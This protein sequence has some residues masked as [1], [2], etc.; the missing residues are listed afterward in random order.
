M[1]SSSARPEAFTN[2]PNKTSEDGQRR[3]HSINKKCAYLVQNHRCGQKDGKTCLYY[4]STLKNPCTMKPEV[5]SHF[6]ACSKSMII[7]SRTAESTYLLFKFLL[8]TQ[9]VYRDWCIQAIKKMSEVRNK[10][11]GP[12]S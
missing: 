9:T 2:A 4:A 6:I 8:H 10:I 7:S 1:P 5:K 3:D 12:S 11:K